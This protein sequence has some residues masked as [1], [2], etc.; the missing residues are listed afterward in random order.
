VD[1]DTV[2]VPGPC[3]VAWT[4]APSVTFGKGITVSG[5]GNVT[6]NSPYAFN[7]QSS[8]TASARVTGFTFT[9]CNNPINNG[10]I[11]TA[12]NKASYPFRI[13][14]NTFTCANPDVIVL[15]NN[16]DGLI[17]HNS[18]TGGIASEMIH[19]MAMGA[20]DASGW[21]DD[22]T[23]GGPHFVFVEDNTFTNPNN[24]SASCVQSYYGARWVIRHNIFKMCQIDAHGTP[25]NIGTRWWEA[26][27]NTYDTTQFGSSA[28][29]SNYTA[30]RAG[31]GLFYNNHH[32]GQN[33]GAGTV[34]LVEEDSGFPAT[35]QIGR[36]LNQNYSPAYL[37]G[38]DSDMHV[39][40]QSSNV[41]LGRDFFVSPLQPA[42]LVRCE[43]AADGG[44]ANG[45][46]GSCL[47]T[48]T[49]T[50]YPYPHPLQAASSVAAPTGLA[51]IVH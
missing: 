9:S 3:S 50:P 16:A 31:S 42:T 10:V 11:T 37:W 43:M 22:V 20:T 12:G 46:I 29:L 39:A 1:G 19:N 51:A 5:G 49:Y 44:S 24:G 40:S 32:I 4:G 18:I 45:S 8:T 35:Y 23:P 36:G 34:E 30:F 2:N 21:T 6:I 33:L 26:Y 47:T 38:N 25:G 7:I 27:E 17:D 14:H 41:V 48:F 15:Y 28:N 13:D